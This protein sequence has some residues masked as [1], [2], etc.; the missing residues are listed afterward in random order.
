[1]NGATPPLLKAW[2]SAIGVV[3]IPGAI[4]IFLVYV[5]ATEVPRLARG[6]EQSLVESRQTRELLEEQIELTKTM[7]QVVR[8]TCAAAAVNQ[9]TPEAQQAAR[10]KCYER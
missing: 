3:G 8:W 10:D 4:A 5:G 6:V 1:M 7:L 2:A 9:K